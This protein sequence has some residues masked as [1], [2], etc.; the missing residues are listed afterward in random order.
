MDLGVSVRNS[1]I[2]LEEASIVL[3]TKR[4]AIRKPG[5]SPTFTD[6]EAGVYTLEAKAEGHHE[7]NLTVALNKT[8]K[9]DIELRERL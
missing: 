8:T 5:P 3:Q 2:P 1:R 9:I 4:Y 7:Q 6:L